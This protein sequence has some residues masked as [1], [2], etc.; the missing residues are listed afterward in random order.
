V[1]SLTH[2]LT[3]SPT[4]PP[5]HSPTHPLTHSLT[6]SLIHSLT[7][8]LASQIQSS[9]NIG[10][11]VRKPACVHHCLRL[12]TL[13]IRLVCVIWQSSQYSFSRSSMSDKVHASRPD[14]PTVSVMG[15][16]GH[17]RLP[18]PDNWYHVHWDQTHMNQF[19]IAPSRLHCAFNCLQGGNILPA[20]EVHE[21]ALWRRCKGPQE[22]LLLP[23]LALQ[24][25]LQ[26][27]VFPSS[28]TCGFLSGCGSQ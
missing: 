21:G 5:T 18:C 12:Q 16:Q 7:H 28:A 2:S 14:R 3:H 20:G 11:F 6:H 17:T 22:G 1:H 26:I 15:L 24:L 23:T 8:S 10:I 13:Y 4:H 9:T 25:L 19:R 27:Q